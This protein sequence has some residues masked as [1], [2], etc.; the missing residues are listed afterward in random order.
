MK[1]LQSVLKGILGS[2]MI[3][4][5]MPAIAIIVLVAGFL[6]QIETNN[7]TNNEE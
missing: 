7:A 3:V 1:Y 5:L 4:F 2:L 6:G